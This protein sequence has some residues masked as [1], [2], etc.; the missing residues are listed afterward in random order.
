MA[1]K[2][3]NVPQVVGRI[4][5]IAYTPVK[6]AGMI[7]VTSATLTPRGIEGDRQFMV[8]ER[9]PD[10]DG[11]HNFVTQRRTKKGKEH[12]AAGLPIMALIRPDVR[13][14][15]LRLKWTNTNKDPI[16]VPLDVNSGKVL[17]VGIWGNVVY[18]VD[19]GDSL[20]KWLSE[21]LNKDVRLVKAAGPFKRGVS[22]KYA[23]NNGTLVFQDGY[24]IHWF[25]MES[26]YE[27]SGIA[28]V[29][30]SWRRFRPNI[31][32]IGSDARVEHL[33][34][35]GEING[36][37]FI[38][39]KPCDRCPT[40]MV[41]PA[42][43]VVTGPEPLQ[44]LGLYKNWLNA[45]GERRLIFGENVLP[46]SKENVQIR[47]GDEIIMTAVRDPQLKYG[48]LVDGQIVQIPDMRNMF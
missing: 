28:G 10:S 33:M 13:G 12:L 18:A 42:T 35:Q 2:M 3:L 43:G 46:I 48:L 40:T 23:R 27:L 15:T 11:V 8:V 21:H 41:D 25:P 14:G 26:V 1:G 22:Q 24:P 16:D 20:A 38:Q 36:M 32:T 19:Q 44:S 47:I 9:E 39:P 30:I 4:S 34:Y 5:N 45:T 7:E 37:Q 17:Y 31:T 29:S 6:S